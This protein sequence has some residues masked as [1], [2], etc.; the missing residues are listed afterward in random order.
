MN[1]LSR[2]SIHYVWMCIL[3]IVGSVIT[4]VIIMRIYGKKTAIKIYLISSIIPNY[5]VALIE[6]HHNRLFMFIMIGVLIFVLFITGYIFIRVN[7]LHQIF[8]R[9]P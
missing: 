1:N 7:D 6:S 8:I 4:S 3:T 5:L 2:Y 9:I